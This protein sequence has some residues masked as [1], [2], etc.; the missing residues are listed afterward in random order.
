M[1]GT[2]FPEQYVSSPSDEQTQEM[3]G[4]VRVGLA[5]M[6]GTAVCASDLITTHKVGTLRV[7]LSDGELGKEKW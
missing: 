2:F 7:L 4:N 3:T 5:C 1:P 6:V